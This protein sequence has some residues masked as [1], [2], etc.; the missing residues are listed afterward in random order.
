MFSKAAE[1]TI[2]GSFPDKALKQKDLAASL[3]STYTISV[4]TGK[5]QLLLQAH[6]THYKYALSGKHWFPWSFLS[7]PVI[8]TV[9]FNAWSFFHL[10]IE[11]IQDKFRLLTI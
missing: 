11:R 4:Y 10:S 8:P 3:I 9:L 5:K 7:N 2:Y 1:V 6:N